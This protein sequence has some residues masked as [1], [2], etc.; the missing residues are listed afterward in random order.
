MGYCVLRLRHLHLHLHLHLPPPQRFLFR[1]GERTRPAAIDMQH[2]AVRAA[3]VPL[4]REEEKG[5]RD[6]TG[7]D[8]AALRDSAQMSVSK[9][10]L[11]ARWVRKAGGV[12]GCCHCCAACDGREVEAAV[13]QRN[14]ST[15]MHACAQS[16]PIAQQSTS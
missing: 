11:C 6:D 2:L 13:A 15:N 16:R 1:P 12:R 7:I 4:A 9:Q 14:T 5:A 10:N 8:R 3:A